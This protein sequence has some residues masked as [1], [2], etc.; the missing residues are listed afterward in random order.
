MDLAGNLTAPPYLRR[1][2]VEFGPLEEWRGL[3]TGQTVRFEGDGTMRGLHVSGSFQKTVMGMPSPSTLTVRN[4]SRDTRDAIREGMTRVTVRAGWQNKELHTVFQGSVLSAVSERSGADI[5]TKISAAPGHGALIKGISSR[6]FKEGTPVGE[7]VRALARDLP[8]VAVSASAVHGIPG[9]INKGG[10]SFAGQTKDALTQLANEYGFSWNIDNGAFKAVG[11]KAMFGGVTELRGNGGGLIGVT[12]L[13]GGPMQKRT[14][15]KIKA[16]YIP[17]VTAG[18]G[19][20]VAS[21]VSP[22]LNGLY[23]VHTCDISIDSHSDAWTMDI[24]ALTL[25]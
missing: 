2:V 25:P 20:R 1:I 16:V 14:G 19:V 10:W 22:K 3:A 21:V 11:D 15:V 5:V 13:L 18:S 7:V 9:A 17:G 6:S 23:R 4:L 8:G 12:P 24:D